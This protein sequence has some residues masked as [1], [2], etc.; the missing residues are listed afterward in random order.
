MKGIK[1]E[2]SQN[3]VNYKKATSYQLKESYP[4]PPYSTVIGMVH[5]LCG[6]TEYEPMTVSV[7]GSYFSKVNDLYTRYE[8]NNGMKYDKGRHQL[9]VGEFGIGR[10]VKT[11]ELLVDVDLMLH[12][13]PENQTKIDEIYY[14]LEN[15]KEY[16]TLGRRE[17]L[18][19][20]NSVKVVEIAQTVL[21]EDYELPNDR[22]AYI[23]AKWFNEEKL[24]TE[25]E[26]AS[27]SGT[28]FLLTK[29]YTLKNYG[30]QKKPKI[31]REW[32]KEEVIYSSK[33]SVYEDE[34][35]W[36]DE[37]EQIVFIDK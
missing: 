4:L 10:G 26:V 34:V 21:K 33:I 7:Q 23:P 32:H 11:A 25:S 1:L 19:I 5:A 6:Y 35:V 3:M 30:T 17:D 13:V 12:I 37:E 24:T 20:F 9:Q 16:P 22:S 31:F 27:Q 14:A 15:P 28:R 2:L 18:A 29:N 36:L 8:F